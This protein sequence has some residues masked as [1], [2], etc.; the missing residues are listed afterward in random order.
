MTS[1]SVR[2]AGETTT[3]PHGCSLGDTGLMSDLKKVYVAR[4]PGDAHLLRGMLESEGIRVVV[5][6]DDFVPL[7]GGGL[8]HVET[9][10]SVWVLEDEHFQRAVEI[11]DEYSRRSSEAP[12][13]P[14]ETWT[15]ASCGEHV[16]AQFTD[17][18]MCGTERDG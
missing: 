15:C 3:A 7:Q 2:R 9:R 8:F 11:A 5:R 17:C 16:E 6:G 10:P 14:A 13:V 1:P 18:W 4:G 12:E